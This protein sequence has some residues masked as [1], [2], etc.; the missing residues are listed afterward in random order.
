VSVIVRVVSRERVVG[1]VIVLA[2][3]YVFVQPLRESPWSCVSGVLGN[4]GPESFRICAWSRAV[5]LSSIV[6]TALLLY[7]AWLLTT[8]RATSSARRRGVIAVAAFVVVSGV[9]VANFS[10]GP[11]GPLYSPT[12]IQTAAP[13]RGTPAPT[14]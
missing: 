11:S 2:G 4:V 13:V 1:V 9:L 7:G 12:P 5:V 14:R 8:S 10:L 6:G 3:I